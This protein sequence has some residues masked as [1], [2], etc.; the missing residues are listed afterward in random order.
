MRRQA[1]TFP[2]MMRIQQNFPAPVV[3]DVAGEVRRE[4]AKLELGRRLHHGDSIAVP[5]G[6][7]GIANL[8]VIIKTVVEE[9]GKR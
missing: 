9:L 1:I 2:R 7:R 5:V 3:E 6:S 8:A 4:L